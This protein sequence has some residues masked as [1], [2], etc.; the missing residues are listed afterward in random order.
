MRLSRRRLVQNLR[1][2]CDCSQDLC[3]V[4]LGS[5]QANGR[6]DRHNVHTTLVNNAW[7]CEVKAIRVLL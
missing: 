1:F 5:G 6:A 7:S 4:M 3:A 2:P